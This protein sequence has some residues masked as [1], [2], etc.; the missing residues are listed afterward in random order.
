LPAFTNRQI[1]GSFVWNKEKF[2]VV[3]GR[4]FPPNKF[5]SYI[6][7]RERILKKILDTVASQFVHDRLTLAQSIYLA[8]CRGM[9][10]TNLLMLIADLLKRNGYEV[11]F[12][13]GEVTFSNEI[14]KALEEVVDQK[15][16]KLTAVLIDEAAVESK[17]TVFSLLLKSTNPYLLTVAA[18][19]PKFLKS[20]ITA[21]FRARFGMTDMVLKEDDE[22]FVQLIEHCK[23]LKVTTPEMTDYICRCILRQCGGHVFPTLAIIEGYF[24]TEGLGNF[25]MGEIEFNQ[26][27]Y[28]PAFE[29]TGFYPIE[30][31]RG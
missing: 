19:V 12:F 10:K 25:M 5:G 4:M 7:G 31:L 21:N 23:G 27:F 18:A 26:H 20:G 30:L 1:L 11:Y 14:V 3:G 28:G 16:K 13:A 24:A 15:H 29:K 2:A 9:G 8:G 17:A 6:L 22:D